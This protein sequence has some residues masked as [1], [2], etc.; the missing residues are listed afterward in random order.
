MMS[1]LVALRLVSNRA[2]AFCAA[3]L[4]AT[5]LAAQVDQQRA[6]AYF[7]QAAA[8]CEREGGRI[9]GI[10][11]C[12][13]M[14]FADPITQTIATNQ[15]PPNATKPAAMGFANS[16]VNWGGTRWS[17]FAWRT[18]GGD[19]RVMARLMMHELF[20]RIQPELGLFVNDG[21]NEHLDTVD[22]RY[23]LQLEW[24]ALA[25]ALGTTSAA[26]DSAVR[27]AL[28]F[29]QK[30]RQQFT[31][32]AENERTLEINEGLAQYTGTVAAFATPAE[33]IADAI[34][35]LEAAPRVNETLV[36]TFP[37]PSGVAYGL[38]LDTW[39]PG[40]PRRIKGTDDIGEMVMS[41]SRLQPTT[42]VEAAAKR[43]DGPALHVSEETRAK[44]RA[45]RI[46]ELRKR[47][48]DGPVLVVPNGKQNS[49][50]TS[51]MT[52]IPGEGTVYPT[53]RSTGDW[54]TL[55]AALGLLANDYS[56]IRVPAPA[57]TPEGATITGEGWTLK[58]APGWAVKPGPR[59][60]DWQVVRTP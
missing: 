29:R 35:Q 24:R 51:G 13:P 1:R 60:G 52:P 59:T 28:G 49:F 14:A 19:E 25:R 3:V 58:L 32:S 26:R 27:D 57:S 20:H 48:V 15:P 47:F 2:L 6:E 16:A 43:Y 46:A 17:I 8:L 53:L 31:G 42:D 33:A 34:K 11:L 41:A 30:R 36:R 39:S 7:K 12:G 37:Y 5:P 22:G 23:W 21:H 38:L 40:W 4:G 50:M 10:S 9:W 44:E 45:A 54:G 55:E 56:R 18:I